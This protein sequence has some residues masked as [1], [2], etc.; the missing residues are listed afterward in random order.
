MPVVRQIHAASTQGRTQRAQPASTRP[1]ISAATREG[2]GDREADVAQIEQRRM[3]DEAGVLQQRIELAALERRGAQPQ[4]RVRGED[5]EAQERGADQALHRPARAPAASRAAR[6]PNSATAA[7][8]HRQ[9]QHPQQHRAFV[10]APG[11]GEAIDPAAGRCWNAR[12][13]ARPRNRWPDSRRQAREGHDPRTAAA[14]APRPGPAP[15]A[16]DRAS[17]RP[18]RGA[19]ACTS[20]RTNAR[21]SANWPIS[22]DMNFM[23]PTVSPPYQCTGRMLRA[24]AAGREV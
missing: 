17:P 3:E 12:P 2:E 14:A 10:A 15:S 8:I 20:A 18:I 7:A 6:P 5:R 24:K 19:A 21:I 23:L 4:E 11:R 1:S 13:P 16:P 22:A 9:D